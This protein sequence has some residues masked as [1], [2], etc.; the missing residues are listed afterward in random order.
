MS[1]DQF[2]DLII[3]AAFQALIGST[4]DMIFV[5]DAEGKNIA[6]SLPFV[7]MAGKESVEELIGRT[8]TEIFEPSLAKRYIADDNK[9][10]LGGQ[11][12]IDY[13]EPILGENGKARY[14]T[15]SK[16]IL[17]DAQGVPIG[18]VGITKDITKFYITRQRYHQELK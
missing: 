16:Y 4:K 9:L 6:A 15:T 17:R 13:N 10:L 12:L 14:A 1:E 3:G 8:D 2:H 18:L 5:K 7:K 11:D